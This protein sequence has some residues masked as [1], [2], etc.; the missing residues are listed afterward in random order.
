MKSTSTA[1]FL[2]LFL[3]ISFGCSTP[4]GTIAISDLQKN[5]AKYQG[6]QV[7]VV[8]TANVQTELSPQMFQLNNK[9]D[10]IWVSRPESA[11]NPD[12]GRQVRVTGTFQ[13]KKF[14][15]IGEV[16]YIEATKVEVE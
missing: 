3:M 14:N 5:T 10:S 16:Y 9:Y 15:V 13:K 12:Q 2:I 1:V 8:G 4:S 11:Y 7:A 6:Q